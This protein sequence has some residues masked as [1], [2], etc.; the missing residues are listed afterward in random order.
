MSQDKTF[1]PGID[2]A[3]KTDFMYSRPSAPIND[4]TATMDGTVIPKMAPQTDE[5]DASPLK[6]KKEGQKVVSGLPVVGF[7]YSISNRGIPEYWPLVLGYNSIGRNP[8]NN[9]VL[10][11][12]TVSG[13]HASIKIQKKR[14]DDVDAV[15][16][17]EQGR[18]GVLLNDEDVDLQYGGR[19][20][21][22]DVITI[23]SNYK[24]LVIIINAKASGLSIARNFMPYSPEPTEEPFTK[25]QRKPRTIT[26]PGTISLD[27]NDTFE[28]PG[29]TRFM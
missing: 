28:A 9:I 2:D 25:K 16:Q 8:N 29:N 5:N 24:F 17:I 26:D 1:V 15:I 12:K 11:E 23:G 13:L 7:L 21:N 6:S 3:S 22:G 20:K 19:C 18:T 4:E 27:G 10:N 14:N